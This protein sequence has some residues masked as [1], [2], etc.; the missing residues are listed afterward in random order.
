MIVLECFLADNHVPAAGE[1]RHDELGGPGLGQLE[2]DRVLVADVDLIHRGKQ[3]RARDGDAGRRLGD[4]VV[5]G[6]HVV[7]GEVG[8]VVELHVLAQ[9]EGV[10]L[11]VLGDLPAVGEI[12]DDCLAAVAR[13]AADEIVEHAALAAEIVDRARLVHVEVRRAACNAV[14]QNAAA[15]G[16][17]LGRLELEFGAVELQ[18][19][20]GLGEVGT[21]SVGRGH[22][23]SAALKTGL[24]DLAPVPMGALRAIAIHVVSSTLCIF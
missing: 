12:G 10:G 24:Q 23:G 21:Q 1:A 6:L 15:L 2:L 16:I 17:G 18:R 8:A 5:G 11:A 7:G 9:E 19:H 13:I 22:R 20:I 4:A 14:A 3:D